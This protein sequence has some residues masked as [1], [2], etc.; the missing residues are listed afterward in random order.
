[1]KG[2]RTYQFDVV[3]P[4]ISFDPLFLN[5]YVLLFVS[6]LPLPIPSFSPPPSSFCYVMFLPVGIL[7]VGWLKSIEKWSARV[8]LEAFL[9]QV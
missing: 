3:A 6:L 5:A 2:E 1:M 9:C 4:V 8:K 7:F